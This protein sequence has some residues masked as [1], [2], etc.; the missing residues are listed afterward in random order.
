MVFVHRSS[1][2]EVKKKKKKAEILKHRRWN[3]TFLE[4]QSGFCC[5]NSHRSS[6]T[7]TK[8]NVSLNNS[9]IAVLNR[10][11]M[12]AERKEIGGPSG[13]G[14]PRLELWNEA[15][16]QRDQREEEREDLKPKAGLAGKPGGR[17]SRKPPWLPGNGARRATGSPAARTRRRRSPAPCS[18]CPPSPPPCS[19]S[20]SV[21]PSLR[22]PTRRGC[23]EA[24]QR[25]WAFRKLTD[26]MGLL[27][28]ARCCSALQM[29]FSD[30]WWWSQGRRRN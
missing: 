21:S 28:S 26:E 2:S 15:P 8:K 9:S 18:A 20:L 12:I 16:N 24:W 14:T 17:G 29:N 13:R 1:A 19:L 3:Q 4:I 27:Q 30:A 11:W 7:E 6:A 25:R 10:R 5:R 23:G 22:I